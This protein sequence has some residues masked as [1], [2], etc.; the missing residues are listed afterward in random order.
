LKTR[1]FSLLN[2]LEAVFIS[3]I[4]RVVLQFF[5]SSLRLRWMGRP[6]ELHYQLNEP[7]PTQLAVLRSVKLAITRCHRYVPWNTE[8]YTQAL[9][10]RI[11]LRRRAIPLLL[12]VGFKKETS[13]SLQGHAW[14]AAGPYIVTGFRTDLASYTLNGCFL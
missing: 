5:D 3:A 9:T 11:M 4:V 1:F 14:T 8:C 13:Q 10:A 7:S 2:F 12:F 6:V